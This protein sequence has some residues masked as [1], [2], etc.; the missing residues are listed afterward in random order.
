MKHITAGVET[1]PRAEGCPAGSLLGFLCPALRVSCLYRCCLESETRVTVCTSSERN[2][3]R[4]SLFSPV[5]FFISSVRRRRGLPFFPQSSPALLS[6]SEGLQGSPQVL[7]LPEAIPTGRSLV[8]PRQTRFL[9]DKIHDGAPPH[10]GQTSVG[11]FL[12]SSPQLLLLLLPRG[13]SSP[14]S[15][16]A[17]RQTAAFLRP[18][19]RRPLPSPS[20]LTLSTFPKYHT[21]CSLRACNA[22]LFAVR[23]LSLPSLFRRTRVLVSCTLCIRSVV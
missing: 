17:I 22:L 10:S 5:C 12:V 23:P 2:S 3:S 4:S 18:L 16:Q 6:R 11:C 13:A 19:P 14:T 7:S 20:F 1:L 9:H 21:L 8:S 15:P